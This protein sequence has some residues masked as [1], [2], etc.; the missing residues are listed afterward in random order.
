MLLELYRRGLLSIWYP[1]ELVQAS[2]PVHILYRYAYHIGAVSVVIVQSPL[3]GVQ[4]KTDP[5]SKTRLS[6]GYLPRDRV[7][8]HVKVEEYE[9]L[10]TMTDDTRYSTSHLPS[11]F[12]KDERVAEFIV[13]VADIRL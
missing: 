9:T 7:P 2:Y 5:E 10:P 4:V 11:T 6:R 1:I 13:I 12:L 3:S 8:I